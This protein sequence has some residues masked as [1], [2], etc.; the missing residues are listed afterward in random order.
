MKLYNGL[1]N[2]IMVWWLYVSIK[3]F[4]VFELVIGIECTTQSIQ[5]FI[6]LYVF[7]Y[8][9]SDNLLQKMCAR[10]PKLKPILSIYYPLFDN[11]LQTMHTSNPKLNPFFLT[12]NNIFSW[13]LI[14]IKEKKANTNHNI[15]R[16]K[17]KDE[18]YMSKYFLSMRIRQFFKGYFGNYNHTNHYNQNLTKLLTRGKSA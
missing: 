13:Y 2:N 5:S 6:F 11:L 7:P 14:W 4:H 12:E 1:T 18:I 16:A 15:T 3:T 10:N 17:M 9:L 8:A